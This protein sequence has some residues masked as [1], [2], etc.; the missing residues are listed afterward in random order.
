MGRE[1]VPIANSC[2]C[3]H[4]KPVGIKKCETVVNTHEV[5]QQAN[6]GGTGGRG[7][8]ERGGRERE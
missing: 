7:N 6:P 1:N 3:H 5:V 2:D 4:H 8:E